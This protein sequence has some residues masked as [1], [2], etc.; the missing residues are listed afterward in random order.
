MAFS[1]DP[2]SPLDPLSRFAL[3]KAKVERAKQNLVEM[4]R[5]LD[6]FNGY[7][8]GKDRYIKPRFAESGEQIE[9]DLPFD[10]LAAA[11]DV[12]NNLRGA[13]D[14]LVY[15]LADSYTSNCPDMALEKTIFPIGK[16]AAG[17]KSLRRR[18]ENLIHP[19]AIKLIDSMKPYESGSPLRLLNDL[20]NIS[21]HRMLL[22]V[23]ETVRC[24]AQWIADISFSDTFLYKIKD[25]H[26]WGIYA[27]PSDHGYVQTSAKES[28][29][30]PHIIGSDA[31]LPTLQ[32]LIDVVERMLKSFL[33]YL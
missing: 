14:H 17:Y 7:V 27:Y 15:Q 11:G 12:I 4:E 21:K 10:S 1:F 20:N 25:P 6:A 13:L 33:V 8:S 28:L 19:D 16:D 24:H 3:V 2:N 9:F 23:G 26:F 5:G 29:G 32:N 18:I 31:L 22:T 30:K